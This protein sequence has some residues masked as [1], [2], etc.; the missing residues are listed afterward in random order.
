MLGTERLDKLNTVHN[1]FHGTGESTTDLSAGI[2]RGRIPGGVATLWRKDC[3]PLISV[4][5]L[6]VDWCVAIKDVHNM[7]VFIIIN[8]YT[9]HDC[10]RNEEEYLDRLAFIG[11]FIE[12]SAYSNIYVMGDMNANIVD[13]KYVFGQSLMQF[14]LDNELV[15]SSKILL[16][17][18]SYTY[19]SMA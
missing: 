18:N 13:D 16:P 11:S 4:I 10:H 15:L 9:P 1:V 17:E 19:I 12:E 8:V 6:E 5:R 2:V 3:D 7:N 14:C